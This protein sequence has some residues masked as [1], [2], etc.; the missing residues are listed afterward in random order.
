MS[1]STQITRLQNAKTN[2]K[3]AIENKGVSVSDSTKLDGYAELINNIEDGAS[4]EPLSVTANGTYTA[5]EGT[6]YSPVSVNVPSGGGAS[7][8]VSG[9]FNTGSDT[10]TAITVDIPYTGTGYPIA[11]MVFV[12]GGMYNNT[13][14][15]DVN[16]YNK[17]QNNAVGMFALSKTELNTAPTY[18]GNGSQ[19]YAMVTKVSKNSN[20][21]ATQYTTSGGGRAL[22]FG[23]A[24]AS[25][26]Y[27]LCVKFKSNTTMSIFVAS[28]SYGLLA[29]TDYEY[30]IIYSS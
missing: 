9:V 16:W 13:E 21:S 11:A 19:N 2:I 1:I 24:N 22:T 27:S 25:S 5:P 6:A 23:S 17:V 18:T 12:K 4:V 10:G 8:Y 3:T 28:T 7:N 30:H 14:G 29:D 20:S 15:G 26:S